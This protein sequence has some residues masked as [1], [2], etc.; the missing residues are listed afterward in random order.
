MTFSDALKKIHELS[1]HVETL[2]ALG[3]TFAD[4]AGEAK[5]NSAIEPKLHA[6]LEAAQFDSLDGL[7]RDEMLFLHATVRASLRKALDLVQAP[8]KPAR[9]TFEDPIILQTQ[10]KASRMVT[11][12]ISRFS[13]RNDPFSARMSQPARFLDVGS[14]V[15][16]IAITMADH[17]PHL[18]VD[19]LDIHEPALALA[20][21]NRATSNSAGRIHFHNRD[22]VDLDEADAYACALIPLIFMPEDVMN[23]ALPAL[24]RAIE[25]GGLLFVAAYRTPGTQ[26]GKALSNLRTTRSGGRVW[27]DD[28]VVGLL[29]EHGFEFI[30][31]I[32]AGTPINLF[33]ARRL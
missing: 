11:R 8:E 13:E 28:E 26:L 32:G 20:E 12:M 16:W 5:A 6:V 4:L 3:A 21:E 7:S 19:G 2:G 29:T 9:W 25:P 33:A 14:G 17:W 22:I 27:T 1:R 24:H 15:G 10:G 23:S 30:E 31:D 18:T